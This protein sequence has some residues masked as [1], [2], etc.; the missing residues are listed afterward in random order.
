MKVCPLSLHFLN[1]IW[2]M[3]VTPNSCNIHRPKSVEHIGG[4]YFLYTYLAVEASLSSPLY[5]LLLSILNLLYQ[6]YVII[7]FFWTWTF[8]FFN[9]K[10][11]PFWFLIDYKINFILAP[12]AHLYNAF[13]RH[14]NWLTH[15]KIHDLM[16]TINL[17]LEL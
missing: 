12:I 9:N 3:D 8:I 7:I 17:S 4:Y 16:L 6:I 1:K 15:Y 14:Q 13:C 10:I 5:L 2:V 11:D